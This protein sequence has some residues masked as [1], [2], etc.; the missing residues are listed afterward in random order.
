MGNHRSRS[1]AGMAPAQMFQF[2]RRRD[3]GPCSRAL[4]RVCLHPG[5]IPW[6]IQVGA[7]GWVVSRGSWSGLVRYSWALVLWMD[8]W[9]EGGWDWFGWWFVGVSEIG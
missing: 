9:M 1:I 6:E 7:G 3:A 8:G 5:R 2:H 4:E